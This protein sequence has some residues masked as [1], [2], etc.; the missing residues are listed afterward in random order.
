M[1]YCILDN[2]KICDDCGECNVCDLDPNKICDNCCRCIQKE[3]TDQIQISLNDLYAK[4]EQQGNPEFEKLFANEDEDV[5]SSEDYAEELFDGS[6]LGPINID[7]KLL[8]EWEA[9]L[10]ELEEEQQPSVLGKNLHGR[11][12]RRR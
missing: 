6:T 8:E 4:M 12:K 10:R 3:Y 1:K 2:K 9:R 7:P 11:R 5:V